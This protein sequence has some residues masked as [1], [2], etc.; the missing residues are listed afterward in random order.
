MMTTGIIASVATKTTGSNGWITR[1]DSSCR[2][3]PIV[4]VPT[5]KSPGPAAPSA[6][7]AEL[8][9]EAEDGMELD[10]IVGDTRLAVL[11]VE[12]THT[13]Q[14]CSLSDVGPLVAGGSVA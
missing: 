3:T 7:V 12:E 8:G 9:L 6:D 13:R 4:F 1:P 2:H 14:R 5:W 10:G 11:E